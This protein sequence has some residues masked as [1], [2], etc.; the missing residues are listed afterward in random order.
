MFK[1]KI[2]SDLSNGVLFNLNLKW[3]EPADYNTS[4]PTMNNK[5]INKSDVTQLDKQ[6][7]IVSSNESSEYALMDK[8][9]GVKKKLVKKSL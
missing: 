4:E 3:S 5:V 1:N 2:I 6:G 8:E 7:N 9:T